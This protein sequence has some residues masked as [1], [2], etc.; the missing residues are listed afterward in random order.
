MTLAKVLTEL[1]RPRDSDRHLTPHS[2]DFGTN[3]LL[4]DFVSTPANFSPRESLSESGGGGGF[5]TF[6]AAPLELTKVLT[7]GR[8]KRWRER[9]VVM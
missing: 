2:I 7:K 6:V 5:A 3:D 1:I 9:T 8:C 4:C